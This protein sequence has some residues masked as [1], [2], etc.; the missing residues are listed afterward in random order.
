MWVGLV[1][2]N[3]IDSLVFLSVGKTSSSDPDVLQ[4]TQVADLMDHSLVI[5][6][7]RTLQLIRFDAPR[8]L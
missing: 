6:G 8:N 4:Q 2:Q 1:D 5:K 3:I 7:V